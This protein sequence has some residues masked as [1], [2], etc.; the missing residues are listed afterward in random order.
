MVTGFTKSPEGVAE[1]SKIGLPYP[2]ETFDLEYE[3]WLKNTTAENL[4]NY[5]EHKEKEVNKF[6]RVRGRDNKEYLV[7]SFVHYRLDEALNCVHRSQPDIG[8]YPIPRPRYTV[9]YGAFGKQER[10]IAE[11]MQNDKG[12]SI[13]FTRENVEKIKDMGLQLEGKVSYLLLSP[14]GNK[15]SVATYEDFRDGR[16]DEL[17]A[18]SKIPT[19]RQRQRWLEEGGTAKNEE[20]QAQLLRMRTEGN[21]PKRNVTVDEVK[22]MIRQEQEQQ[23]QEQKEESKDSLDTR[24]KKR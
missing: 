20:E 13:P 22:E 15:M 14:N 10:H 8:I 9:S 17:L 3:K 7:Y 5:T 11:V 12:Y 18:F 2:D 16:Y 23:E 21:V 19:E 1:Y 4:S 6:F 24:K